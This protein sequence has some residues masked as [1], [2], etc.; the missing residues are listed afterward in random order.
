MRKKHLIIGILLIIASLYIAAKD[1]N[2][3]E[4][5]RALASANYIYLVPALILVVMSF[6]FRAMRWRYLVRSVKPEVRTRDLFSPLMVGF[7]ANVLPA[8]AG[9]FI[10]AYLLSKKEGISFSSSF[11]TI[12]IERLFDMALVL[13]LLFTVI[14]FSA[15][16]FPQSDTE[17]YRELM[18]YMTK[19]GYISLAL[20]TFI[21]LF[22]LLLH[23][24]NSWAMVIVSFFIR[25]LSPK[26]GD[27][28]VKIVH[29]FTAGL[30]I[31]NDKRG[32]IATVILSFLIW[33]TFISVYYPLY[34]AFNIN[35]IPILPSLV[36]LCLTVAIFITL[37]PTP[38]FLGAFQL[39]CVLALNGIFSIPKET[40]LSYGIVAWLVT[41]GSTIVIGTV[42][43]LK[44]HISIGE[45]ASHRE[46]AE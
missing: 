33:G 14:F 42:F 1:V 24:R 38:G 30:N 9:E 5:G 8:R 45:I 43:M 10:R 12:F 37:F 25:P 41:M 7:M 32:F 16:F 19:F 28:I 11:A 39:G 20:C 31:L 46:E 6:L 13:M 18:S 21:L 44:D 22:S 15:D 17:K 23:F 35:T 27:K 40:A 29:S 36:I 4:M 2:L 34:L 26:L 3:S